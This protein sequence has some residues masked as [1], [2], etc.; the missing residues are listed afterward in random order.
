ML[1]S[2]IADANAQEYCSVIPL[3]PDYR[4]CEG[5]S[6]WQ[7][8]EDP[9]FQFSLLQRTTHTYAHT[10]ACCQTDRNT[11]KIY[12]EW[13]LSK[14]CGSKG[15]AKIYKTFFLIGGRAIRWGPYASH[16]KVVDCLR[17]IKWTH[18]LLH[19]RFSR[20]YSRQVDMNHFTQD[21]YTAEYKRWKKTSVRMEVTW[22]L[23][24][25]KQL[26]FFNLYLLAVCQTTCLKAAAA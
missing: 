12:L 13:H 5:P 15:R 8:Y 10:H 7:T 2:C 1:L 25:S 26:T 4:I 23:K 9:T 18:T 24:H 6:L 3:R 17:F 19:R 16:G 21:V 20:H 22:A 11:Y 14:F